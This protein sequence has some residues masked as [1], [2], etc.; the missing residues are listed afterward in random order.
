MTKSDF[1]CLYDEDTVALD[2]NGEK[3]RMPL[4]NVIPSVPEVSYSIDCSK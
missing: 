4:Y 2:D 3:N 1:E